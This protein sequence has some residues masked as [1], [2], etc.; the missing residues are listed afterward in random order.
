MYLNLGR[1]TITRKK[2]DKKGLAKQIHLHYLFIGIIN[3]V[4]HVWLNLPRFI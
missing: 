4:D 1:D 3:P 2:P